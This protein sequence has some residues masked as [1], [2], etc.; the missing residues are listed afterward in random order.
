VSYTTQL[1]SVFGWKTVRESESFTLSGSLFLTSDAIVAPL[2]AALPLYATGTGVIGLLA[3]HKRRRA[4]STA[5]GREIE[6]S[7]PALT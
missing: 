5:K 1:I 2:P 6:S 7:A 4:A 3:W